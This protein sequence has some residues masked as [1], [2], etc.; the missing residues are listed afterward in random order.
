MGC[1][2]FSRLV[3]L[4]VFSSATL[5]AQTAGSLTGQ[6]TDASQASIPSAKVLAE[7]VATGQRREAATNAAGRYVIPDLAIGT[8]KVTAEQKGFQP[9]VFPS[10]QVGVAQAI[11]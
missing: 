7:N 1:I 3:P 5:L 2:S 10:V 6:V 8:Y 11:T 4:F 9:K